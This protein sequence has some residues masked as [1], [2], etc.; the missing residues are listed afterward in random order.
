MLRKRLLLYGL[1]ESL[2]PH[3]IGFVYYSNFIWN[4]KWGASSRWSFRPNS[5]WGRIETMTIAKTHPALLTDMDPRLQIVPNPS[6]YI[7]R[8]IQQSDLVQH[9][10]LSAVQD[11]H[12]DHQWSRANLI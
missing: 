2:L 5:T 6:F 4:I 11:L 1:F 9:S 10:E 8:D 7:V 3:K 12:I